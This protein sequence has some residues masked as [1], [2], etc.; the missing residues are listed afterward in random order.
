VTEVLTRPNN[1]TVRDAAT[2]EDTS[3][4]LVE[5]TLKALSASTSMSVLQVRVLLVI[6]QYGP[7]GLGALANQLEISAPSAS[8]LVSR[9]V[10]ERLILRRTPDHDRRTLELRLSA[11]GR[12]TLDRVRQARRTAI[13]DV[14]TA[15]TAPD[16][17]ALIDGLSGFATAGHTMSEARSIRS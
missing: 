8:R 13:A 9:L 17:R 14:L 12:R 3:L 2:V 10:D 15:M 1:R 6:D 11:K 4:A 16:R 7:L 5:L